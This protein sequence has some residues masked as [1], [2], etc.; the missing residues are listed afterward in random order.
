MRFTTAY[1]F[2]DAIANDQIIE[3]WIEFVRR[4]RLLRLRNRMTARTIA[5]R[6]LGYS[7]GHWG[8]LSR[9]VKKLKA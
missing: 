6:F 4:E 3:H 7:L 8:A 5:I 9:I 1:H 2:T